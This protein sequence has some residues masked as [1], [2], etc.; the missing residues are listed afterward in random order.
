VVFDRNRPTHSTG[1]TLTDLL[2]MSDRAFAVNEERVSEIARGIARHSGKARHGSQRPFILAMA[3]EGMKARRT[4]R[5]DRA[6]SSSGRRTPSTSS[7]LRRSLA[8]HG[9]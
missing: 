5:V 7:F 6:W 2:G 9:L 3:S 8:W 4:R 1:A